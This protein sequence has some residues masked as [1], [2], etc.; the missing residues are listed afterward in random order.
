MCFVHVA[1]LLLPSWPWRVEGFIQ[2]L[3]LSKTLTVFHARETAVLAGF[4][5]CPLSSITLV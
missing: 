5:M 1:C 2:T 4:L 3:R